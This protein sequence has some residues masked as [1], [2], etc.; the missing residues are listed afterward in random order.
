M[1]QISIFVLSLFFGAFALSA[2]TFLT[3]KVTDLDTKDELVGASIKILKGAILVREAITDA[4]GDA[5]IPL[6]L[7]TYTVEVRHTDFKTQRIEGIVMLSRETNHVSISLTPSGPI[8]LAPK[9]EYK[10]PLIRQDET[11][12]GQTLTAEKIHP[13]PPKKHRQPRKS[14]R[15]KS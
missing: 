7:G 5:R 2:Q 12:T 4:S 13:L 8:G 9:V 10:I 6:D 1:K 14:K 3:M 11:S 15:R